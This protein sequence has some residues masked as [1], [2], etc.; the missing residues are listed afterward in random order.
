MKSKVWFNTPQR[1]VYSEDMGYGIVT[2]VR[3]DGLLGIQFDA[4]PWFVHHVDPDK[5]VEVE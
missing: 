3:G 2:A 1:K 5:V 4:D